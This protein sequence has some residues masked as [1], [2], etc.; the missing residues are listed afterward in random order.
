MVRNYVMKLSI[1]RA[2][3]NSIEVRAGRSYPEMLSRLAPV[4]MFQTAS[5]LACWGFFVIGRI[6]CR[7]LFLWAGQ[8]RWTPFPGWLFF[9]ALLIP[10]FVRIL[11]RFCLR[12]VLRVHD[13]LVMCLLQKI[14][15]ENLFLI[16]F[17]GAYLFVTF[18]NGY[19]SKS[20]FFPDLGPLLVKI[21]SDQFKN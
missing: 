20:C 16:Y 21:I 12:G 18:Q 11:I 1:F 14:S 4:R 19:L 17:A 2:V 8:T 7:F 5:R 3:W 13:D 6:R 9:W 15:L 10:G